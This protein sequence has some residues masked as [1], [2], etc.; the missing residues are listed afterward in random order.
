MRRR[1]ARVVV[2]VVA[3]ATSVAAL[4]ACAAARDFRSP[5]FV[6]Q[7]GPLVGVW[8]VDETF[9][10][11]AEQPF[12]AF[13]Q[14]RSWTASDGCN[15]VRGKWQLRSDGTFVTTAGPS[16][17]MACDGAQLP[18]AVTLAERVEVDGDVMR[19]YG[20]SESTVTELV[21]STDPLV[22]PQGFPVGY[23]AESLTPTSP[24]L[25]LSADRTFTG[26]DGCNELF[27]T[28]ST[29]D[30]DELTVFSDVGTT[31]RACDNV[32]QWLGRLAT[33]RVMSGVMTLQDADGTVIGQLMGASR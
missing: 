24:Y 20:S 15:R 11:T 6:R 14:D 27:G 21:R 26:S 12:V 9:A 5:L 33:A 30:D 31:M 1:L 13:N 25:S 18:L 16:T 17:L 3:I 8:T 28:W 2:L 29:G 7:S 4:T 22:G 19:L 32:D 10:D 23:W